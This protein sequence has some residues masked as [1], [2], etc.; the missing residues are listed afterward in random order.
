M[1]T[2]SD[3]AQMM[4]V[5]D[6]D[7]H[8]FVAGL[9]LQMRKLLEAGKPFTLDDVILANKAAMQ[10]VTNALVKRLSTD[11]GREA[12]RRFVVDTF[13]PRRRQHDNWQR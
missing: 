1:T 11:E 13:F 5:T 10:N 12:G 7:A 9:Q 2:I 3:L 8:G 6:Q 4:G